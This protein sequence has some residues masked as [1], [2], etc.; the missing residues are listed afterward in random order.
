[1]SAV[2]KAARDAVSTQRLQEHLNWFAGV[3]R[4]TAGPGEDK[5]AEYIVSQLK[6]AGVPV[7]IHEFDAFLSY[8]IRATLEVLAP[9]RMQ[10]KCLTHSFARST[11]PDGQILDLVYLE[12]GNLNR[13]AGRAALIDG[14]ATPVTILGA[15]K[16]GC[17]AV[18]FA[19]QD[20]V[21]H[22]MIGTTIWGTPSLD[23]LD[24]L[25]S[26]PVISVNKQDGEKLKALVARGEG[27]VLK[28]T[29]EVKTGWFKSKLPEVRIPGT[30]EPEKFTLV[31]AHYCSWE[32][33]ITDNATGDACLLEMAR[34]LWEQRANL[35]RG[36]RVCWWPGHSHGRYSGSTWYA[37]TFFTDLSD[38][39]IA[40]HNIDSPGVKGAT[41]YIARHTS[42]EV[43]DFCRSVIGEIT[44]QKDAPIHRPSRAADQSFLAN[45]V[46]AFSTYPFLPEDHPDRRPWTGGC[47]NAWWWHSENDTL[48][49]ADATILTLDTQVSLSAV[50]QLANS[51]VLPLSQGSVVKEI[52]EVVSGLA[53]QVGE[54]FDLAPIQSELA[55]YKEAVSRLEALRSTAAANPAA[56]RRFNDA[57]MRLSRLLNPIIYSQNGR[58]RH[59]PAEWSPIMRN[60]GLY[61]LSG[62]TKASQL[63]TLVGQ[64][65][66]GFLK[67][68]VVRER[69]RVVTALREA[70]GL[71][72]DALAALS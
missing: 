62:L 65:E 54:H 53:K 8:P 1:M 50:V 57:Q 7:T 43:E 46:P 19:N 6:A 5:A 67:T 40:Y 42:A 69:N 72:K 10:I 59:D 34:V 2:A 58:F 4:D 17:G 21:I 41:L 23:Q 63:P 55:A 70:T 36:A 71:A 26:I 68:Q 37:D 25:P 38:N 32:I 35:G 45:G 44:G 64:H 48:D 14:L 56:A 27:V 39:C 16:A 66:Y 22:N 9:E 31:G 29:T 49:K 13:G 33:G 60:T 52:H 30:E 18:I 47:A 12:D 20:K 61:T 51:P 15:S 11:G 28:I 3:R 24:R